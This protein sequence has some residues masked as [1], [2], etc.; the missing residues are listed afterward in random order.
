MPTVKLGLG[1]QSVR[2]FRLNRT[3]QAEFRP[4]QVS[5]GT[6]GAVLERRFETQPRWM[7]G[8]QVA[9]TGCKALAIGDSRTLPNVPS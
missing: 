2:A 3:R 4:F 1:R 8:R 6:V 5:D 7:E 9:T